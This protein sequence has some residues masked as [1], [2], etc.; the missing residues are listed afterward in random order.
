[1]KK[2]FLHGAIVLGVA[3]LIIKVLG[4]FFRIPLAN[5]I[6]EEGMGYYQTAYP[7]YVLLLVL[8]T[9]GIPTAISKLVSAKMAVGKN[10]SAYKIFKVSFILMFIIG[11]TTAG[12]LF[13]GAGLIVDLLK[14]PGAKFALMA[15]AP[16]LLFTPIMAAFRGYFQGLQNMTPTALSQIIEQVARVAIGL[17]LAYYLV[18]KGIEQA[19]AGASFG[20][21]IGGFVGAIFLIIVYLVKRKKL[22]K[23]VNN[24]KSETEESITSILKEI[25][26]IAVPITIGASI[27]PIMNMIDVAIVMRRLQDIGYSAEAAN[28]LYGQL[29]GM[30][31]P[32]INFPQVFAMSM[33]MSLVPAV[34]DALE[35]EDIEHLN[36][37]IETGIKTSLL[38]AL[39]CTVGIVA[40]SEPIMRLLYPRQIES[41][42]SAADSLSL[43]ALGLVGLMVGQ[44]VTGILQ[45][46]GKPVIPVINLVIGGVFKV[47]LTFVLTGMAVMN[48]KGAAIGTSVAYSISAYLNYLA[49]K[50]HSKIKLHISKTIIKPTIASLIMG[51]VVIMTFNICLSFT[52]SNMST[53]IAILIGSIVY[54]LGLILT[55]AL[56]Y[57]DFKSLPKGEKLANVCIKLKLLKK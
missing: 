35:R 51:G 17:F 53:M 28:G 40:L 49:V 33:A 4:A 36:L 31:G 20:A 2:T 54:G 6:G 57:E 50:K 32:I 42:L 12:I 46:M 15:I 7:I 47:A 16:A 5:M 9:S 21:S 41:A 19:A 22:V 55:G 48:I 56:T 52:S 8:S 24:I 37:N 38:L 18:S 44:A 26:V 3:G 13:F 11:I 30:A 27:M 23:T 25:F 14:N 29:T 43:L 45:G 34:S 1:M 10:E 39:P